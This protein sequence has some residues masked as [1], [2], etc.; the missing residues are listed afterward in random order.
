MITMF[1]VVEHL[2]FPVLV[3]VLRECARVLRPGGV[4]VAET[5]NSTN[6]Q[7]AAST[8][9]LDPTHQR[10]LHPDLLKFLA[11]ECGFVKVDGWFLHD[12]GDAHPHV[13][14][15]VERLRQLVDGPGD[16]SLLA[17]T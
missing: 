8:F 6:L 2:P 13:D 9:W 1:Q 3:D 7:V 12:L 16:F 11:V 15:V 17:W 4:L 5:P 10:P 14:P